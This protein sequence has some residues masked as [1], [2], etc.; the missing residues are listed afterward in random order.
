MWLLMNLKREAG[1]Q[2][3]KDTSASDCDM[4]PHDSQAKP[5]SMKSSR[6][7][8]PWAAPWECGSSTNTPELLTL[9]SG[10]HKHSTIPISKME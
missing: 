8:W 9:V 3:K 2:T 10:A 5:S 1:T 6:S 4:W 7:T